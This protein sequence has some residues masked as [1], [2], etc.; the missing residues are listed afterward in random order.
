M[1]EKYPAIFVRSMSTSISTLRTYKQQRKDDALARLVQYARDGRLRFT[2]THVHKETRPSFW[3][4]AEPMQT[5]VFSRT[6]RWS[7][8]EHRRCAITL[9][10]E[11]PLQIDD[12]AISLP[13]GMVYL[14]RTD[15]L[16][17]AATFGKCACRHVKKPVTGVTNDDELLTPGLDSLLAANDIPKELLLSQLG[18]LLHPKVG[19]ENCPFVLTICVAPNVDATDAISLLTCIVSRSDWCLLTRPKRIAQVITRSHKSGCTLIVADIREWDLKQTNQLLNLLQTHVATFNMNIVIFA[20]TDPLVTGMKE[21][22]LCLLPINFTKCCEG[23]SAQLCEEFA[24]IIVNC[25]RSY[26]ASTHHPLPCHNDYIARQRE[27]MGLA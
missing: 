20:L 13:N 10:Q 26:L 24:K 16:T 27:L 9:A 12:T 22:R 5:F 25:N 6:G 17:P 11:L 23:Y 3:M 4:Q 7:D 2:K 19:L 1:R 21:D 14:T 18:R 8:A 15:E